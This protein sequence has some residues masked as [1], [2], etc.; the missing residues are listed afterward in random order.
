MNKIK[1]ILT[2][3]VSGTIIISSITGA[4]VIGAESITVSDSTDNVTILSEETTLITE[5][6]T[7]EVAE[8]STEEINETEESSEPSINDDYFNVFDIYDAHNQYINGSVITPPEPICLDGIDVSKWQGAIDWAKV[9]ESGVDFAIIRAGYGNLVSQE[10][11]TF[12]KNIQAAQAAGIDC[13]IYWYSYATTVEDAYKEAEACYEVIKDY[14][15]E[16]PVCFDIEDKTQKNLSTATVSGIIDAFCSTM[17]GKGYYVSVY[18]YANF[19]QTKVY[20]S[21]LEKYDVWVAHYYVDAPAFDGNYGMW[22][23]TD[24]GVVDGITENTVDLN[25]SYVDYPKII[26]ENHLNGY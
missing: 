9:K 1:N 17:E 22:Q 14:K 11:P 3:I 15:L 19:L 6:L 12:D 4:S 23:Y 13:G 2:G 26:T 7:A 25:Y 5:D 10:D 16:Y 20:A 21:V 8:E 24:L 18:S